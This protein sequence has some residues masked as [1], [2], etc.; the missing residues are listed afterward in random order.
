MYDCC[1]LWV[2]IC[3]SNSPPERVT[4]L[5]NLEIQNLI[6]TTDCTVVRKLNRRYTLL[7]IIPYM[8]EWWVP[9]PVPCWTLD[10]EK[11]LS[12]SKKELDVVGI[13]YMK[14]IF[15]VLTLMFV[16]K[17]EIIELSTYVIKK[18]RKTQCCK[19]IAWL[20]ENQFSVFYV[21]M[22]VFLR[23]PKFPIRR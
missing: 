23:L 8:T 12:N 16:L 11:C 22:F 9:L 4:Y 14:W 2:T 17:N 13:K 15:S 1:T 6:K 5:R 10:F 20:K 7:H 18:S 19:F 3:Q 21:K